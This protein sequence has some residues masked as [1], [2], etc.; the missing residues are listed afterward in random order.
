MNCILSIDQDV[1]FY[2]AAVTNWGKYDISVFRVE[3]VQ[4]AIRNLKQNND[5]LFVGINEDS[6]PDFFIL[7]PILRDVTD[8]P[9][10]V[11]S[12]TY[13][14]EKNTKAISLG[15]DLYHHNH[16]HAKENVALALEFI[17]AQNRRARQSQNQIDIL[18]FEDIILSLSRRKVYVN[19]N[20][21]S[22]G[23]KEFEI[24]RYLM[25][26]QTYIVEHKRLLRDIWGEHYGEND[27]DILW[28]TINRLRN[29]LSKDL[30]EKDYIKIERGVGYMIV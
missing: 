1:S 16:T 15:A 17:K 19:E 12:Y 18:I 23:K 28:R 6:V 3:T 5:Y 29:K 13:T 22:L 20:E 10:L 7:L 27:T 21:I 14:I 11:I 4:E 2:E 26:N 24:L 30:S 9:I 8:I 25:L